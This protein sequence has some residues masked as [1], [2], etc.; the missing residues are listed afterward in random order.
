[1]ALL[2]SVKIS[3]KLPIIMIA[4]AL[5]NA[6]ITGSIGA[7]LSYNS[8]IG[9]SSKSF[10]VALEERRIT[11]DEFKRGIS[12]DL[13]TTAQSEF[14]LTELKKFS[15]AFAELGDTASS[16]LQD[17]YIKNNPHPL[18]EKLKLDAASDGSTYSA[19]HA[20]AHKF[21]RNQLQAQGYYDIFLINPAGN[22]VYTVFK[23]NDFSTNVLTGPWKDTDLGGLFR[24]LQAEKNPDPANPL[25]LFKDFKPYAPSNNV[26]AAFM[27]TAIR[28]ESGAFAGALVFQMPVERVNTLLQPSSDLGVDA[29]LHLIGSDFLFRNNPDGTSIDPILKGR[30]DTDDVKRALNGET[31][32]L[33]VIDEERG[34][35]VLSNYTPF[36]F[37]GVKYALVMHV[38][39]AQIVDPIKADMLHVL[40]WTIGGVLI[41]ALM[42]TTFSKSIAR[43][44]TQ[45]TAA[46]SKLANGDNATDIPF[47]TR[48]DELGD[49]AKTVEV[50][51]ANALKVVAMNAEAEEL[52][53]RAEADKREAMQ[54]LASDF[55]RRV[56]GVIKALGSSAESLT[57]TAQQMKN[58]SDQTAHISTIVA[59]AATEA[60]S[61][62]Q[63]VA[64]ASEEL[65]ASSAE[66][67]RQIDAVAKKATT[68]SVDAQA[69]RASV[70][71]LNVLADSIG[72]VIS[73][74]KDIADQTNLLALNATIE[75]AR[76][77]EAGK[78]FAVVADEVKKLANET[79]GKTE[80][81]DQRVARIQEAI[82][83]S[84]IAMEKII[85]NVSQIDAATTSVA[86]AVE[87]QNA[88]TAEIGRNVTEASTGTQQVSSSI[89]Q[90]QSNATETGQSASL[91][92][93]SASDLKDQA[94]MLER[95]VAG[96]LNEIRNA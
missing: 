76:A 31:G 19:E 53:K 3:K 63:T 1:M 59:A 74:I 58:A 13:L 16:Y 6:F 9:L 12:Q 17:A 22:V 33:Q 68:A 93:A 23:E 86:S 7:Y 87:Q 26:P 81:I 51:K 50:F 18:G 24:E 61:N 52:K 48:R 40:Y 41:V 28:D 5:L 34:D 96:F 45:L 15:A 77:G 47:T 62:V 11:L 55:D 36:A 21:F 82:R 4:L 10:L 95:E 20:H 64:A 92:F 80:E 67:A 32:T 90:V 2:S 69:T 72:E 65:S 43:P 70:H 78:G 30:L 14:T 29:K 66:I 75:A 56:G 83:N 91:V 44:I 46:M 73:T 94:T 85:D 60:D 89:T 39:L 71:E 42:S 79:S 49:M 84:V 38:P 54:Q 37:M 88:A 25:I 8:Q 27:G 57:A 35:T